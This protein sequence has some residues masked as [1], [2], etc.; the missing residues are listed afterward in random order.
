MTNTILLVNLLKRKTDDFWFIRKRKFSNS[1]FINE[2]YFEEESK[3]GRFY[4][5]Y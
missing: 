3:K 1:S 5:A 2:F 4:W